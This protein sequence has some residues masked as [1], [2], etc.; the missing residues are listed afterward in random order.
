MVHFKCSPEPNESQRRFAPLAN[1]SSVDSVFSVED[2]REGSDDD[3]EERQKDREGETLKLLAVNRTLAREPT[4][5]L[6][7]ADN[8]SHTSIVTSVSNSTTGFN[9][10]RLWPQFASGLPKGIENVRPHLQNVDNVPLLV[11]LFTDTN[12]A[13]TCEMIR[14]MQEWGE[15]V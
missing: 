12:S 1:T 7:A 8:N 15:V 5:M 13:A 2:S 3:D 10:Q 11:P 4:T 6:I 14:I 9:S